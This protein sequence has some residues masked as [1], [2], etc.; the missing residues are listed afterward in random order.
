M[1]LVAELWTPAWNNTNGDNVRNFGI[2]GGTVALTTAV[3]GQIFGLISAAAVNLCYIF[4]ASL[5][6]GA[7]TTIPIFVVLPALV[8]AGIGIANI[9]M[10]A[11]VFHVN[12]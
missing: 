3:T 4:S 5:F 7:L 10:T 1:S 11:L 12:V 2:L 6:F 9:N 8:M